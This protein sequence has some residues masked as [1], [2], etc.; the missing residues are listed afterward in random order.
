MGYSVNENRTL[1]CV[2]LT[3]LQILAEQNGFSLKMVD[4]S[5]LHNEKKDGRAKIRH[6]QFSFHLTTFYKYFIGIILSY[7]TTII[8]GD[9]CYT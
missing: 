3:L 8:I 9:L 6:K 2:V 1:K 5:L 4:I 7:L